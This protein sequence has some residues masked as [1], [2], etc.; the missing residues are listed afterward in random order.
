MGD[1]QFK[2]NVHVICTFPP[3][4]PTR[5]WVLR[6]PSS[7][8][9]DKD[10][11]EL[12]AECACGVCWQNLHISG[13]RQYWMFDSLD[14]I[15]KSYFLQ[16]VTGKWKNVFYIKFFRFKRFLKI[17]CHCFRCGVGTQDSFLCDLEISL[18]QT[19]LGYKIDSF[20]FMNS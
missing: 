2:K 18:S 12:P 15:E 20:C 19:K 14:I 11:P 13:H 7:S 9:C 10:S 3:F 17:L 6:K 4:L 1:L 8:G 5:R 16:T